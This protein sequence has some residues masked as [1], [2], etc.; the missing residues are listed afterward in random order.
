MW[1][2]HRGHRLGVNADLIRERKLDFDTVSQIVALHKERYDLF[3]LLVKTKNRTFMKIL[4][5]Q[6]T[7]VEFE[8]QMLWGF[9][10]NAIRHRSYLWPKCTCPKSDN[11][12]AF[13]EIQWIDLKCPL[14]GPN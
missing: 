1:F 6:L 12:D 11:D 10:P 14:H 2:T 7:Q 3:T 8:L 13:P 4:F 5:N 9:E